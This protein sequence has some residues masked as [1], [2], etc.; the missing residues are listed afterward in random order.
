M[1]AIPL[2]DE[3]LLVVVD[4]FNKK[5]TKTDAAKL[6]GIRP[7]TYT[8]RLNEARRRGLIGSTESTRE[9]SSWADKLSEANDRIKELE[10][11]AFSEQEEKLTSDYIKR[12]ILKLK[13]LEPKIPKWLIKTSSKKKFAGVPTLFASDWHWGEIVDPNQINGVNEYNMTIAQNRAKQ[14]IE[15]AVDLLKNHVAHS[16]YPGIVY[17]LGGDMVSGDI[18]EELQATNE[19]EIMPTVIDLFGVLIWCINTL[20]N[21]FG[22]VFVPCVS[23]NHGRNTHKIRA[24]GRNF[25]S[26]DW[27]LYQFLAKHFENDKRIQFLIPDG[28]DAYYSVYGHKYLLTHGDQFRGGDGVIGALGPIVRGDH[29]KRSRNAQIDMTYDTMIIGHWH[30]L[31]QLER[32]IVNGCFPSGSKVITNMGYNTIE[33]ISIGDKVMSRDGSE[34]TVTHVFKKKAET[35][36]GLKIHGLPHVLQATPNHLIWACK[37]SSGIAEVTPARKDLIDLKHGKEQ[38]IPMDFLSPND[39]VHVPFPKGNET[40]IDE[41]TAW[42]YGL[43]LAEGHA[44]VDG[45]INK[46]HHRIGLTMHIKEKFL[47][48]YWAEWFEKTYGGNKV[49][50]TERY[51]RNTSDLIVSVPRELALWFRETFGHGAINKKLP[52]GAFYW[53]DNLKASLVKGWFAGDG[54]IAFREDSRPTISATSVSENLATGMFYLAR[55]TGSVPALSCLRK[56]GK[57]KNDAYT[58][59]LNVGQ[60]SVEINGELFYQIKERFETNKNIDVYDLEVSGEHTYVVNGVGVH[61]SLKGYDEYAY[62]NNFGFEPPRQAMWITHPEHGITFSIPIYVEKQNKEFNMDWIS[63]K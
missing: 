32:L 11:M 28:P 2:S 56:G 61:N 62:S 10:A 6:L 29:R 20:A 57:R 39:Y 12:K 7:T 14:M 17:V 30:Q 59:H 19:K 48:E 50:I 13:N 58:V 27:L 38:W 45:G 33:N 15:K 31:I 53:A 40:P 47:L 1:S 52:N 18:H 3:D 22:N 37:R 4:A 24:K 5:K 63:W 21:E 34:Q 25:T 36:I 51:D 46:K 54:H 23:G 44:L 9:N 26:F 43:F 35:I 16:D 42:A 55:A 41:Q 60:H 49:R 8:S